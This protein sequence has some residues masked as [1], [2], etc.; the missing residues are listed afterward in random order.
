M[1]AMMMV[2]VMI[3]IMTMII[4]L[5]TITTTIKNKNIFLN[6]RVIL[7]QHTPRLVNVFAV[8]VYRKL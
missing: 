2:V 4:T 1:D 3:I 7:K 5:T 6:F 8:R